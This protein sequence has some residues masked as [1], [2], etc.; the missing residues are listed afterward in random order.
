MLATDPAM[1]KIQA[2]PVD[3]PGGRNDRNLDDRS[4]NDDAP[5]LPE[6]GDVV[7]KTDAEHQQDHAE[8]RHLADGGRVALESGSERAQ[9]HA[10]DEVTDDGG[11]ADLS[12]QQSPNECVSEGDG[13]VYEEW[14]IVHG[15]RQN[16][17]FAT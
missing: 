3:M 14:E 2:P 15:L 6:I 12:R 17:L 9:R 5:H 10:R 7:V 11:Q 1:P 13:D 16:T 4:G 8:F